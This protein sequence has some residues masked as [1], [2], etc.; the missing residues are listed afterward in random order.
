MGNI[1]CPILYI[2]HSVSESGSCLR[3][4]V[5]VYSAPIYRASPYLRTPTPTPTQHTRRIY[6]PNTAQTVRES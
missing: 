5:K 1:I 6:K 4:Q 2:K 3:S